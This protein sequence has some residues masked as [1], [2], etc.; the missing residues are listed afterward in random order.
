MNSSGSESAALDRVD[1]RT[2]AAC[3]EACAASALACEA[4]ADGCLAE[5]DILPFRRAIQL[6]RN[7]A[8]IC[9]ATARMLARGSDF[10]PRLWRAQIE[11][12]A[13]ACSFCSAECVRHAYHHAHCRLC[14]EASRL[15]AERCGALLRELPDTH[16]GTHARP[17]QDTEHPETRWPAPSGREA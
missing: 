13:R 17:G 2:Q 11:A 10:D 9:L 3:M 14:A 12:C 6:D 7:C 15:C 8:D 16:G 5:R 1:P 4:C